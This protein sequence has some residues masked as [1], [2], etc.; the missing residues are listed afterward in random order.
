MQEP[1][2]ICLSRSKCLHFIVNIMINFILSYVF[3][4]LSDLYGWEFHQAYEGGCGSVSLP[5]TV[6][7]TTVTLTIR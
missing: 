5:L 1:G 3:F 4:R 7:E 2:D 6:S